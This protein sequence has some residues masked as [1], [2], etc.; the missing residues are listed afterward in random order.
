MK[1]RSDRTNGRLRTYNST[2]HDDSDCSR[3]MSQRPL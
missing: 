1:I 2:N 3:E